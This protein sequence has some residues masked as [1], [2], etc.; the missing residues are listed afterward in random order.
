MGEGSTFWFSVPL[1]LPERHASLWSLEQYHVIR[2]ILLAD[3][4]H[5]AQDF[6]PAHRHSGTVDP[7]TGPYGTGTYPPYAGLPGTEAAKGHYSGVLARQQLRALGA[8]VSATSDVGHHL[9]APP[10]PHGHAH[11][12][13]H[14]HTH[15]VSLEGI[16][17]DSSIVINVHGGA[18]AEHRGPSPADSR[19]RS[20]TAPGR[21]FR[22]SV[23]NPAT[24]PPA[25]WPSNEPAAAGAAGARQM[26]TSSVHESSPSRQ[27]TAVRQVPRPRAPHAGPVEAVSALYS[28]AGTVPQAGRAGP[29]GA[30]R[31][32]SAVEAR[33]EGLGALG[34]GGMVKEVGGTGEKGK[35]VG[36]TGEKGKE[37]ARGREV[38]DIGDRLAMALAAWK[39]S[40]TGSGSVAAGGDIDKELR[41][42]RAT[43]EGE[44]S[45][46]AAPAYRSGQSEGR[47]GP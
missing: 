27:L 19:R 37:G 39:G 34:M 14:T 20:G 23:D 26:Q 18:A 15:R 46:R 6:A 40:G 11:A 47:Y 3:P 12:H 33:W 9:Q 24:A 29:W 42:K 32:E 7:F 4:A 1:T 38:G 17:P 35:E 36:G 41:E 8:A 28:P 2:Q 21:V 5:R 13:T 10:H 45:E 25:H 43:E 16:P 22:H 31:E 30:S 44:G